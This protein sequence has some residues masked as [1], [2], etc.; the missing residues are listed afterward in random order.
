MLEF[1]LHKNVRG[2][3][4]LEGGKER[5]IM[6]GNTVSKKPNTKPNAMCTI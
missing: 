3:E 5:N 1:L 2:H 4:V 6:L